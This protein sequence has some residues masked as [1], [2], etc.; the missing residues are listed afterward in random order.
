MLA[1]RSHPIAGA[2]ALP[3]VAPAGLAAIAVTA[4]G[5]AR[6]VAAFVLKGP[7]LMPDEYFYS[8]IARSVAHGGPP[9]VR[10]GHLDFVAVLAPLLVSPAWLIHDV[11]VAYRVAQAEGVVAMTLAAVPAF[12]LSR[13]VGLSDRSA[14]VA[15][16]F[17]VLVPD[18]AFSG[19]LLSEPFAYPLFLA[20]VLFA[21]DS[22][23]RP[24]VRRQAVFLAA[25]A[26]LCLTRLQFAVVPLAYL[27]AATIASRPFRI[28]T[29][30]RSHRL[31]S[32]AIALIAGGVAVTGAHALVGRYAGIETFSH[33]PEAVLHWSGSNL[34]LL[35][36]AAGWI[37]APGALV[38]LAR[39]ARGRDAA[40]RA[41]APLTAVLAV[42]FV[43]EAGI[44][45]AGLGQLEERYTFYAAP[46]L[47]IAFLFAAQR[48]LLAT[49]A[50]A[51][52]AGGLVAT[53]VLVP[54]DDPLFTGLRD[55][56][57][58]L[59][60]FG[61]VQRHAQWRAPMLAGVLLGVLGS[62]SLALGRRGSTRSVVGLAGALLVTVGVGYALALTPVTRADAGEAWRLDPKTREASL[63][64]FAGSTAPGEI[65][66]ALFW[67]PGISRVLV[68]GGRTVDGFASVP[69]RL[70][71]GGRLVGSDG[72]IGGTVVFQPRLD[73]IRMRTAAV[74]RS[75]RWA[76]IDDARGS[77]IE[78]MVVGW[79]PATHSFAPNGRIVVAADGPRQPV[80]RTVRLRLWNPGPTVTRLR[81]D[82]SNGVNRTVSVGRDAT[83]VRLP[84][85]GRGVATCRFAL[86]S[87]RIHWRHGVAETVQARVDLGDLRRSARGRG[88][89][90]RVGDA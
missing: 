86:A 47:V 43:L 58:L 73:T 56:S 74:S 21:V 64:A 48:R 68:L 75:G 78:E 57:P 14:A 70:A 13:R 10:G 2:P 3:T 80:R 23:E 87:G 25:A 33:G 76:L 42:T 55:Q 17:T 62:A 45:G 41:F 83:T 22:L 54:L 28:T 27:A 1:H 89:A 9:T 35:L 67:N 71:S 29:V 63:L 60:A 5:V 6:L 85:V 49:R 30:L 84:L 11:A 15:A 52:L 77:R 44:F 50:H 72:P 19:L 46:L 88:P 53:A 7:V 37:T 38:G 12:L 65:T 26:G 16:V 69:V 34:A 31:V 36:V 8:A 82:C 81:F 79:S 18:V 40:A 90:R 66:A 20:T 59:M 51:I 39:Q 32:A 61:V 4:V 24:T